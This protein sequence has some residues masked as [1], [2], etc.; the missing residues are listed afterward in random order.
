[1][2]GVVSSKLLVD[3]VDDDSNKMRIQ[4]DIKDGEANVRRS[5]REEGS[6]GF[7]R[8]V[9]GLESGRDR[10][11]EYAVAVGWELVCSSIPAVGE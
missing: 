9:G 1:M 3:I 6:G 11:S 4:V 5:R 10:G 8:E 7:A 2:H